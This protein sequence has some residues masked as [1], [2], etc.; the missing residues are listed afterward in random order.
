MLQPSADESDGAEKLANEASSFDS[1]SSKEKELVKAFLAKTMT[2]YAYY[3]PLDDFTK[4]LV[5]LC[6]SKMTDPEKEEMKDVV[7]KYLITAEV[8]SPTV[9]NKIQTL[10]ALLEKISTE[11]LRLGGGGL[12]TKRRSISFG[13]PGKSSEARAAVLELFSEVGAV[14]DRAQ[15]AKDFKDLRPVTDALFRNDWIKHVADQHPKV[16]A[17]LESVRE[18]LG[19]KEKTVA[20][21]TFDRLG[22]IIERATTMKE[23]NSLR[24]AVG[25][26][27]EDGWIKHVAGQHPDVMASLES[28]QKK[29]S[30]KGANAIRTLPKPALRAAIR[31]LS[32]ELRGDL[33]KS[34]QSDQETYAELLTKK[35]F[36]P[37]SSWLATPPISKKRK[38]RLRKEIERGW[39]KR[40]K[41]QCIHW[42]HMP[43]AAKMS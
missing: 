15:E 20:L 26:F 27:L 31:E 21:K 40:L 18:K 32:R 34:L 5:D 24:T 10:R 28:V 33:R 41:S 7:E 43:G 30:E 38:E 35:M 9:N 25:T 8:S 22:T 2:S 19:E 39:Q 36:G 42:R 12:Q 17:R 14:I 4:R 29:L 3:T 13:T 23:F 37:A 11:K 16:K 6:L 1:L